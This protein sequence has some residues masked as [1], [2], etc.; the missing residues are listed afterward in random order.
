MTSVL[1]LTLL[2][3]LRLSLGLLTIL[4]FGDLQFAFDGTPHASMLWGA[5]TAGVCGRAWML[6]DDL[7]GSDRSRVSL[8]DLV[9]LSFHLVNGAAQGT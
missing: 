2:C 7:L 6:L 5:F 3:Q 1:A 4:I 9:G 8:G